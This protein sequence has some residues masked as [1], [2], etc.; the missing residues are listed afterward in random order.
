VGNVSTAAGITADG[1]FLAFTSWNDHLVPDDT[2]GMPDAFVYDR[3]T[4]AIERVSV[5]SDGKQLPGWT[6]AIFIS[7][8]GRYALFRSDKRSV[9]LFDSQLTDGLFLHDRQTGQTELLQLDPDDKIFDYNA[10]N[11][12]ISADGRFVVLE[13]ST[14]TPVYGRSDIWNVYLLDRRTNQVKRISQAPDGSPAD[15]NSN[16]TAMTPDGR[17]IAFLSQASNLAP[18]DQPC[19]N[20]IWR[21]AD[22]FVYDRVKAKLERIPVGFG[23]GMGGPGDR[24]SISANGRW[25]AYNDM[26]DQFQ[27]QVKVYDRETRQVETGCAD[28][29]G[30]CDGYGPSLSADGRWLAFANQQVFLKDRQTGQIRQ[31]S[32]SGSG[33]PADGPSG[34]NTLQG[35]GFSNDVFLSADGQWLA[36]SSQAA[37]LLP[38]GVQKQSCTLFFDNPYPCYD[39]FLHNR[40]SG[41]TIWVNNKQP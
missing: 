36:F 19:T 15:G 21:C 34:I 6:L 20:P 12:K 28:D 9:R 3:E 22:L 24:L 18:G 39:L 30:K 25:I 11:G 4:G 26:D 37:N 14:M 23:M 2:N 35:E 13:V 16:T 29:Q 31:M 27:F 8:D 41:E 5:T 38:A 32:V 1:R 33:Q 17:W 40:E 10:G 7:A